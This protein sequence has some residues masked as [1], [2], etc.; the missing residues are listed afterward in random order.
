[1]Q[2]ERVEACAVLAVVG[3]APWA[4]GSHRLLQRL[5]PATRSSMSVAIVYL[6]C[7]DHC[8]LSASTEL[9][10]RGSKQAAIPIAGR[11]RRVGQNGV[12]RHVCSIP[13]VMPWRFECYLERADRCSRHCAM[14]TSCPFLFVCWTLFFLFNPPFLCLFVSYKSHS[15]TPLNQAPVPSCRHTDDSSC[16]LIIHVCLCVCA[17]V[18]ACENV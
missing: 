5:H 7:C 4:C 9:A 11:G 14:S 13:I 1:M 16:V 10:C 12:T 2:G 18:Y 15:S 8:R 3:S 6:A 17:S